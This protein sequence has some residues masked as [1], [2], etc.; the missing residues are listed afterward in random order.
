[1][2][3]TTAPTSTTPMMFIM[4][5]IIADAAAGVVAL[6]DVDVHVVTLVSVLVLVLVLVA[7]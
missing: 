7:G 6:F 1:M 2:M 3:M 5:K 4:I